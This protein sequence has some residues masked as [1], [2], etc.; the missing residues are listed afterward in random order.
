[1]RYVYVGPYE[2]LYYEP[3][4]LAKFSALVN[5]G[6][7]RIVYNQGGVKIYQVVE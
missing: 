3:R 2:R 7:L 5:D 4:A 6:R 1:V